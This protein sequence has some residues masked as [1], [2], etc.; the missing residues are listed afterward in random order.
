MSS[1]FDGLNSSMALNHLKQAIA[2]TWW[3][4]IT[5]KNLYFRRAWLVSSKHFIFALWNSG[6]I[7]ILHVPIVF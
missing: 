2:I 3:V 7:S 5:L 6:Q 1:M 4:S